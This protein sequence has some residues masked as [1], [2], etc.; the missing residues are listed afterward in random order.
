[1]RIAGAKQSHQLLGA[2]VVEP[3][4][5][6]GEQPPAA[7]EGIGLASPVAQGL[8]LHTASALVEL[9]VGELAHVEGVRDQGGVGDHHFED[10]SVG[11]GE[12]EGAV[13][14]GGPEDAALQREPR[15]GLG[16]PPTGDDVEQLAASD[17]DH[18][19]REL[20]AAIA[21]LP[22]EEHL[23]EPESIDRADATG[24][25]DQRFPIGDHGIV[26]GVP[27]AAEL[28]SHL[29]HAASATAHLLGHPAT[30]AGGD[31]HPRRRDAPV[32]LGPRARG[33]V[34]VGAVQPTLVPE[35]GHRTAGDGE[36][37]ETHRP[38]V[39]HVRHN[40]TR[41]AAGLRSPA[42]D[43]DLEH[44]RTRIEADH[45]DLWETDQDLAHP[46]GVTLERRLQPCLVRHR[47]RLAGVAAH[48]RDA[49]PP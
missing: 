16:A 29:V 27:I 41:R 49:I 46:N 34:T 37:D 1:M 12:V 39:L 5:R 17:V 48:I 22:H 4:L 20:L 35:E 11:A 9:R 19:G 8:V 15:H 43:M 33:T 31:R 10:A 23:V 44:V 21:T 14:D 45:V 36:I 42:L 7:V 28:G 18:L 25:V 26:H 2:L 24:H 30:G 3:L 38:L 13:A 6:L 47:L 32:L 40:P